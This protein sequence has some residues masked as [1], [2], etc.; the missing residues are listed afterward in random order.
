MTDKHFLTAE[1]LKANGQTVVFAESCTGGMAAAR[2]IDVPSAS[3]VLNASYVTYSEE[4]KCRLLGVNA[5]TIE[6]FGVVSE[7]VAREMA[8]GAAK[9]ENARVGVGITGIAGPTGG[10]DEIPVGTVCFGF[11]VDGTVTSH[12]VHFGEAGRNAVREQSTD[13]VFDQLAKML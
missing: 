10:T 13:F 1:K 12:T 9:K 5:A 7:E 3:S 2:L 8:A 11:F 6:R 4:A